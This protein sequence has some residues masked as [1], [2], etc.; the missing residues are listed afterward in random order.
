MTDKVAASTVSC[1]IC[2]LKYK[3]KI[4]AIKN[5]H[6]FWYANDNWIYYGD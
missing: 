3:L 4:E 6:C 5:I 2:F 1:L